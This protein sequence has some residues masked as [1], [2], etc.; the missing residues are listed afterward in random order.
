MAQDFSFDI[1]CQFNI[2]EVTNA[3]D[4][5][6]REIISRFDFKGVI[7]EIDLKEND[8]TITTES[9]YKLEALKEILA[10]KLVKRGQ[11]PKILDYSKKIERASGM[12]VR[13]EI[14]LVKALNQDQMKA[15]N[16]LIKD[17]GFKVKTSIQGEKIRVQSAVK[18]E[19]QKTM[20][21]LNEEKTIEAPLSY[22]NFR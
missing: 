15:I 3:V 14:K 22:V 10:S 1:E 6:K 2:Q 20:Q 18:D 8:I 16:K 5:T 17:A 11:S 9:E 4:Q 7:A 19:L 12:N 21:L 13:Q